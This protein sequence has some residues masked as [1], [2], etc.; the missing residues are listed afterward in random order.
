VARAGQR[1][2]AL[3]ASGGCHVAARLLG[4]GPDTTDTVDDSL[5]ITEALEDVE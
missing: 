5:E 4:L 1:Q 2:A 3:D